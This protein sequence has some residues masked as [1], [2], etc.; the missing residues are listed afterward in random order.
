[1]NFELHKAFGWHTVLETLDEMSNIRVFFATERNGTVTLNDFDHAP[2]IPWSVPSASSLHNFSAVCWYFGQELW[3]KLNVP[4]GL[5][6]NCAGGTVIENWIDEDTLKLCDKPD[7]RS[8]GGT[9]YR[10]RSVF[11]V[12]PHSSHW[13]SMANP[14]TSVTIYGI[15]WY[16]GESNINYNLDFY[17]CH[18]VELV[19]DWRKKWHIGTEQS[20]DRNFPFGFVQLANRVGN[21]GD[22]IGQHAWF[23]FYQTVSFLN[24]M[25]F[26][27][28]IH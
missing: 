7:K 27:W 26:Y 23:R 17:A 19:K 28:H 5:I 1:M 9:P 14:L 18:F 13:K 3:I 8:A 21:I 12:W 25:A 22:Y 15:V 2:S 4:I 6:E 24:I 20:T 10:P 16:H 11:T